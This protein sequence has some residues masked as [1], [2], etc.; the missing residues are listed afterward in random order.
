MDLSII[1]PAYNEEA[2]IGAMLDRY[3][4]Y[5]TARYGE[6]CELIVVVN[7]SRDGTAAIVAGYAARQPVVRCLVEPAQVGKGGALL[8]GFA[9]ARGAL[10]GFVDADG[11]TPPEAFDELVRQIGDAAAIIASRWA[12]GARVSPRQPLNRR[13]ASR[14]FNGLVRALFG[15][16]LTD[17]Q[18]GAKL[19]R[20]DVL[21]PLLPRF[22][23]TQW[24][25]DVDMLYQ[26]KRA[27]GRIREIPTTWSDVAGSKLQVGRASLEM[28]LALVRLRL[29]YSP[30]RGLVRLY[31]PFLLPVVKLPGGDSR[32]AVDGTAPRR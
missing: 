24:A 10:I 3:V 23:I 11:A 4:P 5:F 21:L 1:V 28:G 29:M 22:G 30:C 27:G 31:R 16:R 6:R 12:R 18:C 20:R 14:C 26:I 13:V 7:G 25:F 19:M 9:A 8:L 15:L 2:R 32:P 17:T